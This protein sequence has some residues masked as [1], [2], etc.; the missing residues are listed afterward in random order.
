MTQ[1]IKFTIIGIIGAVLIVTLQQQKKEIALI[2]GIAVGTLLLWEVGGYL[3]KIV[4]G[5]QQISE[6]AGV[7]GEDLKLLMKLLA[8]SYLTE[9]GCEVCKD[10]GQQAL[11]GKLQLGGKLMMAA[12]SLPVFQSLLKFITEVLS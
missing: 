10:A 9:F 2:L 12:L 8:I 5:L 6:S 4:E 3:K 1:V 11:A 7:S